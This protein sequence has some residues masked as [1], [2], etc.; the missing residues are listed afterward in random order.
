MIGMYFNPGA[1]SGRLSHTQTDLHYG[2]LVKSSAGILVHFGGKLKCV[3]RRQESELKAD[4]VPV[5]EST[6]GLAQIYI[7]TEMGPL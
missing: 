1:S 2:I 7:G 6:R 4:L 3:L 5:P